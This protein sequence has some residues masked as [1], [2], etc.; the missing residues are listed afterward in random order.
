MTITAVIAILIISQCEFDYVCIYH[1]A[2]WHYLCEYNKVLQLTRV[3]FL[4]RS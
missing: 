1:Y 3:S 2:P 4:E